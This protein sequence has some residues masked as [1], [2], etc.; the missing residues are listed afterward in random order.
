MGSPYPYVRSR[1][2]GIGK[3]KVPARRS[4]FAPVV[5]RN[6]VAVRWGGE[7]R[8]T[9]NQSATKVNSIRPGVVAS[10]HS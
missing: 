6:C 1:W 3:V 5:N 4:W 10:L 8:E 9:N 2:D 7:H